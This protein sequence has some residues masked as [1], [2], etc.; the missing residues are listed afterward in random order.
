[1]LFHEIYIFF[2]NN[3]W[4][5]GACTLPPVPEAAEYEQSDNTSS[6]STVREDNRASESEYQYQTDLSAKVY[7][8]GFLKINCFIFIPYS[9]E[10]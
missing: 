9:I 4:Y 10:S 5:L 3:Y 1:M 7:L 2:Y 8:E 6:V